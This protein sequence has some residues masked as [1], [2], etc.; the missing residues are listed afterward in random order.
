LLNQG[1]PPLFHA[2]LKRKTMPD[3]SSLSFPKALRSLRN[4][5][6]NVLDAAET[7]FRDSAYLELRRIHCEFDNGVLILAGQVSSHYLRQVAQATVQGIT[8][9]QAIDNRLDVVQYGINHGG[10]GSE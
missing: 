4:A 1:T 3:Q 6:N 8:E 7:K 10:W 5:N 9:I 2:L